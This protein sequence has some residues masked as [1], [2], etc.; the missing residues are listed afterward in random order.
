MGELKMKGQE[1]IRESGDAYRERI[2][3][4]G[5]LAEEKEQNTEIMASLEAIDDDDKEAVEQ[6]KNEAAEISDGLA[7]SALES[8]TEQINENVE[9]TV[10]EQTEY[11]S[12]E[13]S[14]ASIA[15]G[16]EGNYSGVGSGL[17]ASFE[18]SAEAFE[19]NINSATELKE[20]SNDQ[21]Q[22]LI[23]RLRAGW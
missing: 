5:E 22:A 2:E 1:Q 15:A 19:E 4:G 16:I 10:E 12:T 14:D 18:Q 21:V 6:G 20:D 7:E 13:E 17:E 23:S 8:P 9:A 11:K 3:E